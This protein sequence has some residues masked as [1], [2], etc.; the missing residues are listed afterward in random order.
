MS[1]IFLGFHYRLATQEASHDKLQKNSFEPLSHALMG[2][3][4]QTT[5][6]SG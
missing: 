5:N 3:I 2:S 4:L 1:Q 6:P